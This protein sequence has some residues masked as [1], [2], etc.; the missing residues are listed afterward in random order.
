[1][2]FL[3]VVDRQELVDEVLLE[4]L[5]SPLSSDLSVIEIQIPQSLPQRRVEEVL[6]CV[7]RA[8]G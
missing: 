1:M 4:H 7:I 2:A 3:L 6:D 5:V 8:A